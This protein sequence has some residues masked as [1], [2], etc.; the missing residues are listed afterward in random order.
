[1][2][3]ST[4]YPL[5]FW[6]LYFGVIIL[7]F[8]SM[9]KLY[10]KANQPGWASII[11]VYNYVI[12]MKIIGRPLWWV[13]LMF[14]PFVNVIIGF[15]VTYDFMKSY[16]KSNLGFYLGLLIL[17][18]IFFPI[19]AFGESKY[20]GPVALKNKPQVPTQTPPMPPS[21]PTPPTPPAAPTPPPEVPRDQNSL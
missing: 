18:P 13:L 8:A 12:W 20:V 14:V 2:Q 11:P 7:S 1:M 9:W 16:G 21:S 10:L 17:S 5:W 6:V 15:I 4:S 19:L 3:D